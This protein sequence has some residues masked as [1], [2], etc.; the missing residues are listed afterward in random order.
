MRRALVLAIAWAISLGCGG[1]G[2]SRST[3]LSVAGA[4]YDISTAYASPALGVTVTLRRAADDGT[5]T[6]A[7]TA[8]DGS[9]V[10]EDVPAS[11]DVYI[12]VGKT[13]YESF[14]SE[15]IQT[16]SSM[17][18][19]AL[20]IALAA[21]VQNEMDLIAW[22]DPPNGDYSSRSWFVMDIYDSSGQEVPGVTVT[23]EPA[24]LMVLYNNGTD[25]F[26]P[27]GPTTALSSHSS[28]G[29]VGGYGPVTGVHTFTLTDSS[30]SRTVKLPLVKG[31]MSYAPVYPW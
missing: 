20:Y 28:A 22:N 2:T 16:T 13:G 12:D 24:D 10:L 8:G 11:T 1:G 5:I 30:K 14:N 21:N 6:T 23:V 3:G 19:V 9:F 31:E 15:V 27:G 4:V 18:A 7:V 26:L 25:V 17:S 29:L